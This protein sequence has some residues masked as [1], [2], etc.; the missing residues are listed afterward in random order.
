MLRSFEHD[1]EH[2]HDFG[3]Y[4]LHPTMQL[5]ANS[6]LFG[7]YD[8]ETAFKYLAMAGYDGIELAAI[9]NMSEQLVLDRWR[10]LAPGIK[11]L[12]QTQR[13]ALLA[14]EQPRQDPAPMEQ[15]MQADAEDGGV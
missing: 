7:G 1:Y 12:A 15:G 4:T 11:A 6:V 5:G 8:M 2:E 3:T 14:V 9:D 10:E 13:L